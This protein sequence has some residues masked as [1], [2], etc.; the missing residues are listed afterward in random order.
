MNEIQLRVSQC[1]KINLRTS[2]KLFFIYKS[3]KA[4]D[5]IIKTD[6][7]EIEAVRERER[8]REKRDAAIKL[9]PR[10]L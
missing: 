2:Q 6:K 7:R 3:K 8:R 5:F 4:R 1:A 10:N 9:K